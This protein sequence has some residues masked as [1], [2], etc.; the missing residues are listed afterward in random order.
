MR[1]LISDHTLR[2]RNAAKD[3]E[4]SIHVSCLDQMKAREVSPDG[5]TAIW[6][7]DLMHPPVLLTE[8][9]ITR[10]ATERKVAMRP[11]EFATNSFEQSTAVGQLRTALDPNTAF[12]RYELKIPV[13]LG[14]E[15]KFHA[16]LLGYTERMETR[17]AE[18]WVERPT[19][20]DDDK[21]KV[22]AALG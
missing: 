11:F 5:K 8:Q 1:F 21:Y 16:A 17:F 14:V 13:G 7:F 9:Q 15:A 12:T 19:G 4:L 18:P 6:Q 22:R 20:Y 2:V 3:I 10:T